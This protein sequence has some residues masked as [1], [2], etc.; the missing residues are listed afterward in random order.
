MAGWR[1]GIWGT[2]GRKCVLILSIQV[3]DK[4]GHNWVVRKISFAHSKH[5][6]KKKTS[7]TQTHYLAKICQQLN[8]TIHNGGHTE[9]LKGSVRPQVQK[10]KIAARKPVAWVSENWGKYKALAIYY[11]GYWGTNSKSQ[12]INSTGNVPKALLLSSENEFIFKWNHQRHQID[13]YRNPYPK[14]YHYAC[15]HEDWNQSFRLGITHKTRI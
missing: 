14:Y 15:I 8:A 3:K 6:G 2:V 5:D 7:K 1:H 11:K 10:K 12:F 4:L 9:L 13:C